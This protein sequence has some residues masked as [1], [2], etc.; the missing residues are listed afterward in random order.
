[1]FYNLH[2][3]GFKNIFKVEV[4]YTCLV[5]N[6]ESKKL[7]KAEARQIMNKD[8]EWSGI[9]TIDGDLKIKC[10]IKKDIHTQP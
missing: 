6:S 7:L 8:S 5:T 10:P 3:T 1:M 2:L 9:K 4:K